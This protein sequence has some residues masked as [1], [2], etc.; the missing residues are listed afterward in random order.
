MRENKNLKRVARWRIHID[1]V[2]LGLVPRMTSLRCSM[3][4]DAAQV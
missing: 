1:D 3:Q 2:I 4:I